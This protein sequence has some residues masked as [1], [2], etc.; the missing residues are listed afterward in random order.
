MIDI[1]HVFYSYIADFFKIW[2]VLIGILNQK[3]VKNK[4]TI[5][6]VA[7]IQCILLLIAG[8][9]RKQNPDIV[10]ALYPL[11]LMI[12]VCFIFE[13][14][15]FKKLAYTI[16][17]YLFILFLDACILGICTAIYKYPEVNSRYYEIVSL[18]YT[19]IS[20]LP[21]S[22]I[23]WIMKSRR[24]AYP[25]ILSKRI[26]VLL[27]T[28]ASTGILF[29][30][31]LLVSLNTKIP[32]SGRRLLIIIT[33]VL[34]ISYFAAC[35]MMIFVTESR[36][37][38]KNLSLISQSIIESQQ[39]YYTLVSEKQQEIHSIRHEMKNHLACIRGLYQ[40]D[41]LFEM[42]EYM[43]QL[44]EAS[45]TSA[46]FIDT[47]ND[48]VNAILNDAQSRYKKD[49][50]AIRLEG[51][52]PEKLKIAPMDLC[53]IFANIISNAVEAIQKIAQNDDAIRY[54]DV[55]ISTYKDDLYIDIKNPIGNSAEI[56]SGELTT[57]K[58]D[59]SLHGFGVKNVIQRVQNYQGTFHF[60]VE[61]NQFLVEIMMKN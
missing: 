61:N 38:Y 53:V 58:K 1:I 26:Y 41:K 32:N 42:E 25:I 17:S 16:L 35:A 21:L 55:K 13:G 8:I 24:K 47:G 45:N 11:M 54:I 7:I 9:F 12:A 40:A 57:T 10:T 59:K 2:I 18:F 14:K 34:V 31:A 39:K 3:P 6:T 30:T 37:S 60:R 46:Y 27:F 5:G 52:F 48:I 44:I 20:L 29:I 50:I 15:L 28:G 56:I 22:F 19:V 43:S 23:A 4:K 33:I 36:D 51:C 49:H